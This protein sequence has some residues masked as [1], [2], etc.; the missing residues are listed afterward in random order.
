MD[1][2]QQVL[3][4]SRNNI[5]DIVQACLDTH[6]NILGETTDAA[7]AEISIVALALY[8]SMPLGVAIAYA[9]KAYSEKLEAS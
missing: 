5:R 2:F 9:V 7:I 6:E 1:T 8:S 3:D 4:M